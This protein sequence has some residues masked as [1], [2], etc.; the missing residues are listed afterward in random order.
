MRPK[1]TKPKKQRKYTFNTPK[2]DVHKI[3]SAP[4]SPE[5]RESKGFR[6][7][8][9]KKGD[10]VIIMRGAHAGKKGK[11]NKVI[12]S[13][14][15]IHVDKVMRGK[16]DKSEIP[17]PIHP[18]NVMITKYVTKR[19]KKRMD[20]IN[21]R[22]KD[23]EELIDIEAAMEEEEEE[24]IEM[25]DEELEDDDEELIEEDDDDVELIDDE[26]EEEDVA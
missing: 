24:S 14:M 9:I 2:K 1:S 23:E 5:L 13:K 26:E 7:L 6:S 16:T 22:I 17:V 12:P 18:S 19:D 25:D 11:V 21:R 4:L 3:M 10:E 20:L 15:R 8:P